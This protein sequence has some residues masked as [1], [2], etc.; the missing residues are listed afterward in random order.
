MKQNQKD[1]KNNLAIIT[2][3]VNADFDAMASMLA[4]QKLYPEAQ[5]VFPGSQ[6]K[7]LR[8]FFIDSMVYLFNIVEIKKIDFSRVTKLILVDTR[9][10][11]RIGKM[12]Q[13]IKKPGI[14]IHIYDHHPKK[15][16]DIRGCVEINQLTGATTTILVE[17]IKDKK[18]DISPEEATIMC[19]GIY[20]DTGS[21]SF[22]ST[23]EKD[24]TAAAF[25]LSKGANLNVVSDMIAR[26]ISP[27]QVAMLNDMI[28]ASTHYNI[29]GVDVVI[30]KISTDNYFPDFAFLVH[31]MVKMENIK[32]IFALALMEN[33]VYVVARSRTEDLDAGEVISILGGGGHPAAAAATIKEMTIAQTEQHLFDI[34]YKKVSPKRLAH[35]LM[36]SP[37]IKIPSYTSCGDAK[38][39][40]TRYNI[41][42]LLVTGTTGI[43]PAI[44]G[45][46]TRQVIEK[47]LYHNLHEVPV[48]EY[49]TTEIAQVD[50]KADLEEIQEKIIGNKQ[51]ILPVTRNGD[52]AGVITRTDLLNTLV[53][54]NRPTQKADMAVHSGRARTKL[55]KNYMEER[56]PQHLVEILADLGKQADQ[57]GYNAY[58]IGGFVRDLFLYRENEDIDIVIEGNGI[59]FSKKYAKRSGARIHSHKK[60][61]TAVIIFP[62][63]FK[64]DVAS[65]RMEYYKFPASLPV[66]EMSSIKMDLYRR[67]FT[68]NTLAI[69]INP[70][71][72][73]RLVDF[74]SAQKD[75]KD[76]VIRILHNLSFVEDPTRVFRA[77]RFEQRFGFTIGKLTSSLIVNA[78]KMDFFKRLS[79]KRVFTE[80]KLTLQENNPCPAVMRLQD[81]D[82]LKVVHPNIKADKNL[83]RQLNTAKK[84]IDWHDLLFFEEPFEKWAVYFMTLIRSCDRK[85][86][87]EICKRFGIIQYY[88]KI[89]CN[90]RFEAERRL[91]RLEK[92]PEIKNSEIYNAISE[93]QSEIVLYMMIF[94]TSEKTKKV[95]SH[96]HTSLRRINIS[97]TGKTLRKLGV[98]PGPIYRQTLKAVLG[99]K[100]DGLVESH[101]EEVDF[102]MKW[103]NDFS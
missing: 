33:K 88:R 4:A 10:S 8:N 49:M 62:D 45:F 43:K 34:L 86:T 55:I 95:I 52:V 87:I 18:L 24:F 44:D 57:L 98:K 27:E 29:N 61:G 99:A 77:L 2:T 59:E 46:I 60:F 73:G 30:T 53:R 20:E 36:S 21:F 11:D 48:Q 7:N 17:I 1:K 9:R 14:E 40:L 66:V 70:E 35:N 13:L 26:E 72:F 50:V 82:L 80:L 31:K 91:Y 22:S 38:D 76:K 90:I 19:L 3:H 103:L 68:I 25:L 51:R 12:A 5:V 23:T 89:F 65:A 96:Y 67:D 69:Q 100:L 97:M 47:A 63:G 16:D 39:I 37:A 83:E 85:M 71:K 58:V 79:G 94:A 93:F 64:I 56:L 78:V 42:A 92:N 32:A 84:V 102:A 54:Q 101:D 6:E 74:F 28:Q 81:Y 75:I 15:S 41:N